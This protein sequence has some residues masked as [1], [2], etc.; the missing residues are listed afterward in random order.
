MR[1]KSQLIQL[2]LNLF[3][4]PLGLFYSNWIVAAV[5]TL[6]AIGLSVGLFGWGWLLVYPFVLI[7]GFITVARHNRAV[8]LDERRH[9]EIV[10]AAREGRIEARRGGR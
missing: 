4:G 8:T 3:L 9:N 2:L 7:T 1:R 5:F 10:D 6:I